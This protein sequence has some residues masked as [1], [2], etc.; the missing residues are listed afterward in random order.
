MR[1]AVAALAVVMALATACDPD[2]LDVPDGKGIDVDTP[3]LRAAKAKAG[4]EDCAPG[5]AEAAEG[6]LPSVSLPCFG[7][8]PEVD[9]ASL[10]GPLVVNIWGYWCGPCRKEMPVLAK[11][12]AEHGDQVRMLGIDYQ[13]AQT[14]G[15][16]KLVEESGVTYPLV[17]DTWG[18]L[19]EH[20]P[21]SPRMGLPIS[22]FVDAGGKATVVPGE[23]ETEQ[24]LVDLVEQHLGVRL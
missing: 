18:E 1:R 12:Y 17:A 8:G 3:A 23:I 15:A 20:Q 9:L 5:S 4:V 22:V 7:G 11:F 16:M 6:G 10:R 19:A 21:F 24:E 14:E 2:Q 13:D